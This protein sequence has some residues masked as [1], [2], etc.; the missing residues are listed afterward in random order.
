MGAIVAGQFDNPGLD[1][2]TAEDRRGGY[3]NA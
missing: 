1:D 3:A 2:K